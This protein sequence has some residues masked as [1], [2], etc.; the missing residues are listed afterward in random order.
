[1]I[2]SSSWSSLCYYC[3]HLAQY[4]PVAWFMFLNE[5]VNHQSGGPQRGTAYGRIWSCFVLVF[6]GTSF[7]T[8]GLV[9][10]KQMLY[11]LSEAPVYFLFWL[12]LEMGSCKLFAWT[13]QRVV[14]SDSVTGQVMVPFTLISNVGRRTTLREN[15][16][17]W[18]CKRGIW[19]VCELSRWRCPL[20]HCGWWTW[21]WKRKRSRR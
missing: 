19:G 1:M 10:A 9:L 15:L 8:Q 12:F 21:R 14:F 11:L 4:R 13:G 6:V 16:L 7:W 17:H 3:Q 18:V 2:D 20:G 5:W